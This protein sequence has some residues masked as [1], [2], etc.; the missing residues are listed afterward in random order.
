[1][2]KISGYRW[3]NQKAIAPVNTGLVN[4]AQNVLE[5]TISRANMALENALQVDGVQCLIWIRTL[6][7][8]ACPCSGSKFK[9]QS[10]QGMS[11]T[12]YTE[13]D[14]GYTIVGVRGY[15][16]GYTGNLFDE[17]NGGE[18][19]DPLSTE[20]INTVNG[21]EQVDFSPDE[22]ALLNMED[23]SLYSTDANPCGICFGTGRTQAYSLFN[24][25]R[26][27]L[28]ISEDYPYQLTPGVVIEDEIKPKGFSLPSNKIS[29]V[30]WQV[31]LPTYYFNV[32]SIGIFN[33]REIANNLIA[34]YS[35]D[36][37]TTWTALT[38]ST[39]MA[40]QGVAKVWLVRARTVA[41]GDSSI[42]F[43][44]IVINFEG[45]DRCKGQAPNKSEAKRS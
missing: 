20:G 41:T 38:P 29:A 1:M 8:N 27:V 40:Q 13:T 45:I 21:F 5:N 32:P 14:D 28:C 19:E 2:V 44:H 31:E 42:K 6:A 39:L 30:V 11:K 18:P 4:V 17:N 35:A 12:P 36:N 10:E 34:E 33:N 16:D 43:T 7:G 25:Q 9:S 3:N 37:G 22:L 23:V 26:V 15:Q 24:G